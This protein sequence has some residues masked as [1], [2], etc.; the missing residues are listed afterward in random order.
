MKTKVSLVCQF[1]LNSSAAQLH[2]YSLTLPQT[3]VKQLIK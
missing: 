2:D 1:D 3:S